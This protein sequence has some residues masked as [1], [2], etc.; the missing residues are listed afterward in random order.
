MKLKK[1]AV[2]G[3]FSF[4][5]ELVNGQTV[6]TKIVTQ[7]LENQFGNDCVRKIDTHGGIKNLP[8]FLAKSIEAFFT[9]Q[10]L[11]IM[12]GRNGVKVIV[13]VYFFLN[14][15]FR[16]RLHCIVIGGWINDFL[17]THKRLERMLKSFDHIYV[18]TSHMKDM[19]IKRNFRNV[20]VMPNF[21]RL[22]KM[23]YQDLI[24]NR[25]KSY[26]LCT[27]SR[28]L[29]EKGIE[30]AINAVIKVNE[31]EC[32]CIYILDLYGQIDSQYEERFKEI[33]DKSPSYITYKGVV[34]Y[35]KSN[36]ILKNYNALLFPTYYSGEGFAA[37]LIDAFA[38]GIPVI[39]SDWRYNREIVIDRYNGFIFKSFDELVALLYSYEKTMDLCNNMKKNC[40]DTARLYTPEIA[41]KEL[42]SNINGV[43][44]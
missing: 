17:E 20:T 7:E 40:I 32:R 30:D 41:I 42:V 4:K 18:E 33:L 19:L 2:C 5:K 39:A 44:L 22:E 8:L 12:P 13:P 1:M 10:N 21:K 25:G 35:N 6:K 9:C 28:I 24:Y 36:Q 15:I 31:K 38:S 11:I 16:R 34:P 14:F 27:F 37:T 43:K 29:K 26:K 3:H 23:Q